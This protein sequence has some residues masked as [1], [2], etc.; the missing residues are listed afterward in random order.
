MQKGRLI[1]G[2]LLALM[3]V[4][5]AAHFAVAAENDTSSGTSATSSSGSSGEDSAKI[6]RAYKCL[7]G[8][9]SNKSVLSLQ[10]AIFSML[11][12]GN[13]DKVSAKIESERGD[14]CWPKEGCKIKDTA[15]VGLA[16][17]RAGKGTGDIEKWLVGKNLTTTELSWYL[18]IDVPS[19]QTAS[20]TITRGK[21]VSK[22]R[23]LDTMKIEGSPGSCFTG[24]ASG[25]ML[26]ISASCLNDEFEISCDQDFVTTVLYQKGST[27]T[28]FVSSETHS[29]AAMGTTKEKVNGKCFKTGATCDY[30]GSLWATLLFQKLGRDVSPYLPYLMAL[31][32][33]NTRYFPYAFLHILTGIDEQYSEVV[34]AQKQSKFWEMTGSPYNRY[35]DTSLAVLSLRTREST[36]ADNAKNYLLQI[37]TKEG[38]W[39][40]NNVRDT[41]FILYAMWPKDA[42]R[43]ATS[44]TTM[45]ESPFSC[46]NA[47]ECT[48]AGG[49][50]MFGSECS[51]AGSVCCSISVADQ[52]CD[53]IGGIV[54]SDSQEC[55][56]ES[57]PSSDG[58]CCLQACIDKP[59]EDVCSQIGGI[60]RESCESGED[61]SS[62]ECSDSTNICC[63]VSEGGLSWFWIIL[64]IILIILVALGIWKRDKLKEW[65]GNIFKKKPV[66]LAPSPAQ[67]APPSVMQRV[68]APITGA[69]GMRPGAARAPVRT[70]PVSRDKEVEETLKKLKDM[71]R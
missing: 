22:L 11:A 16:Y 25:F 9:V 38:C 36:E 43:R 64:L 59:I 66:G 46:E 62:E 71:S 2:L 47:F 30:E 5:F 24:A 12:A 23:I 57:V 67:R 65:F 18:E 1:V 42:V 17:D 26:K 14:S 34:Q 35:Y 6:D 15:Q 55:Q 56:G 50:V 39:N 10:D 8:Q 33:D 69:F 51:N 45:C 60:C 13:L 68:A 31:A 4:V 44:I 49:T 29:S 61:E 54:C 19:K 32:D 70:R 52:P 20:C 3:I 7:E 37:Q 21:D 28:M 41:A 48:G 58:S 53:V 63:V 27:G 40:N